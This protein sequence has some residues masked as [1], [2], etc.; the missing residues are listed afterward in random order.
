MINVGHSLTSGGCSDR[1][2]LV[3]G[4]ELAF[5][6]TAYGVLSYEPLAGIQRWPRNRPGAASSLFESTDH[7]ARR[8]A[9]GDGRAPGSAAGRQPA[10]PT[11]A[12]AWRKMPTCL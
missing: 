10:A 11:C 3:S 8:P 6:P 4:D 12:S 7:G 9:R 2:S 1:G 5:R